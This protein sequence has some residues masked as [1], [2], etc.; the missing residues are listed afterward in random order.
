MI[1]RRFGKLP[2]VDSVPIPPDPK[3]ID[4]VKLRDICEAIKAANQRYA[5]NQVQVFIDL[6]ATHEEVAAVDAAIQSLPNVKHSKFVDHKSALKD[7]RHIFRHDTTL[8][9]AT[10]AQDLPVSFLVTV[11]D[12]P[13]VD[14]FVGSAR[15]LPHVSSVGYPDPPDG[16]RNYY[17]QA[18]RGSPGR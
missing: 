16:F 1:Q 15:Q 4:P 18:K 8:I 6:G 7:F 10:R 14:G 3:K 9:A 17:C 11:I 12:R 5:A 2:G 13:S